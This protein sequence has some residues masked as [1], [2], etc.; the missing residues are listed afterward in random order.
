MTR[1]SGRNRNKHAVC[2]ALPRPCAQSVTEG[3][4]AIHPVPLARTLLWN[5]PIN[6][7]PGDGG[8]PPADRPAGMVTCWA[9]V[10]RSA[11]APIRDQIA[12]G[13]HVEG[14]SAG[15]S[16]RVYMTVG[17]ALRAADVLWLFPAAVVSV[18]APS[19][20]DAAGE[21]FLPPLGNYKTIQND[22]CTLLTSPFKFTLPI[23]FFFFF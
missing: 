16:I 17:G 9:P 21:V 14:R 3:S 5:C 19:S 22:K 18:I 15:G 4:A 12:K 8:A 10:S 1:R 11:A 2:S 6:Q 23:F 7:C 20:S 13:P